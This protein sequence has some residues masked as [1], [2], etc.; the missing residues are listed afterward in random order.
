MKIFYV[1]QKQYPGAY[2]EEYSGMVVIANDE[3]DAK[4]ITP[5]GEPF[6]KWNNWVKDVADLDCTELG[7]ANSAQK[8]GVI[9]SEFLG[10]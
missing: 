9:I 8:R 4:S 1:S 2:S 7:E 6:G 3:D 5:D 10:G